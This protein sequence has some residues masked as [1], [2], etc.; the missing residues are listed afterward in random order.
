MPPGLI[1]GTRRKYIHSVGLH[2]KVRFNA[3]VPS[4]SKQTGFTGIFKGAEYGIVRLS[5]AA[6]PAI[7]GSQPLTPGIALKFLR[8]GIDSANLVSMNNVNG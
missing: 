8:D 4:P 6:K 2:G 7:D 5:S 1:Y 3:Y